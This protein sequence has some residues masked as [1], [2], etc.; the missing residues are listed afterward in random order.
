MRQKHSWEITDELWETAKPLIPP[1]ERDSE[2][3]RKR[4]PG[5]GRPPM[6]LRKTLSGIFCV[7]RAGI[8]RKALPREFGSS[9]SAC[10]YFKC[11]S[12]EIT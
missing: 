4:K 12:I 1:P 10:R 2:K 8:Q 11:T 9:S 3:T 5:G 7:M 6:D